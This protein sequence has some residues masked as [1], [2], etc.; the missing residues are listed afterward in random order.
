MFTHLL[1]TVT[2]QLQQAVAA[3][4][5]PLFDRTSDG[6]RATGSSHTFVAAAQDIEKRLA[7]LTDEL[8][9]IRGVGQGTL[10]LGAVSTAKY[11]VPQL[12][13]AFAAEHHCVELRLTIDNRSVIIAALEQ[14]EVD[15]VL[16]RRP[17]RHLA[18]RTHLIGEHPIVI[19]V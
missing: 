9:A 6:L 18:V 16:M 5:T 1:E 17:P 8:A 15:I 19:I 12:L 4:G 2:L 3:T 11:F 10:R 13:A 7:M 14:Q